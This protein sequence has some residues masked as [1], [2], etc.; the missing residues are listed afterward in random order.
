VCDQGSSREEFIIL[1]VFTQGIWLRGKALKSFYETG[2][3]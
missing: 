3:R 2:I 1:S